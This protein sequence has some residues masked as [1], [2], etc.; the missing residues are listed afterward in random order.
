MVAGLRDTI[1]ANLRGFTR[2]TS[3]GSLKPAAVAIVVMEGTEAL[4]FGSSESA[5]GCCG[6]GCGSCGSSPN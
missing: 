1:E 2:V 3:A 4:D 6:G 5:G